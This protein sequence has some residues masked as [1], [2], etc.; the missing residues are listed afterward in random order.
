MSA[1]LNLFPNRSNT[2]VCEAGPGLSGLNF[3]VCLLSGVLWSCTCVSVTASL[4]DSINNAMESSSF[5]S[6]HPR[7]ISVNIGIILTMSSPAPVRLL[8]DRFS[9]CS[10]Q[11]DADSAPVGL[12]QAWILSAMADISP[13]SNLHS[14]R[15]ISVHRGIILAMS[16]PAPVRLLPPRYSF[17]NLQGD[18]DSAPVGLVQ[19]WMLSAMT[20]ISPASNLHH[21]RSISVHRGIILTML[22]PAPVRLLLSRYSFYSLQG[23]ADSTPVGLVQAWMLS[24]MA[25]ISPAS[26]LHCHI[27]NDCIRAI[28][29]LVNKTC[30]CRFVL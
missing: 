6:H 16:A 28:Q 26:N 11:G 8:L 20:D 21:P 5:R 1:L 23:D 15:Y 9:F 17:C 12:V 22:A 24:A 13:A 7:S 4:C 3:F 10:L 14:D 19:V 18:A 2:S 29:G 30:A 25:D 27:L